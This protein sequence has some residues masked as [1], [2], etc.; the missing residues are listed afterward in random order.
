MFSKQNVSNARLVTF[1]RMVRRQLSHLST[2]YVNGI[3]FITRQ[4][5][6][7]SNTRLAL[8]I[9]VRFDWRRSE[10]SALIV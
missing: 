3:V 9:G 10:R 4:K 8:K 6:F 1:E 2:N 7:L 5:R